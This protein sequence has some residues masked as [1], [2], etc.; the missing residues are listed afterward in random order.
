MRK[1]STAMFT[2]SF[3]G[4]AGDKAFP[5]ITSK[6]LSVVSSVFVACSLAEV[7]YNVDTSKTSSSRDT[8]KQ[9]T[10]SLATTPLDMN[11]SLC[12]NRLDSKRIIKGITPHHAILMHCIFHFS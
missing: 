8:S 11:A 7:Q 5:S 2:F 3:S 6:P 1:H 10:P 4:K 9:K 12:G